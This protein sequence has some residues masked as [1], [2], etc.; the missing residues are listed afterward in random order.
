MKVLCLIDSLG[1]GGAQRQLCNLAVML[2]RRGFEVSVLTYHPFDFFLPILQNEGVPYRCLNTN[3]PS[4]HLASVRR[5]LREGDQ[6]VVLAFLSGPSLYAELAGL[7]NRRWG[8][9][10]SERLARPK[11]FRDGSRDWILRKFHLL[12]D[13]ITTN[14]HTNRLMIEQNSRRAG[15]RTVTI[16]NAIDLCQFEYCEPYSTTPRELRIAVASS[17]QEKKNPVRFIKAIALATRHLSD[18]RLVLD[19]YGG[20]NRKKTG[21]LDRR[22]FD[23]TIREIEKAGLKQVVRLHDATASIAEVY[24]NA[25][26]VALPSLFEG[27][28]N[29][30]C[31]GMA[32]GRP[33]LMSDV[34]DAGN[35]V[36]E[37]KNGFLFDPTSVED[38]ARAISRLAQLDSVQRISFG[39]TSRQMAESLFDSSL[40]VERYADALSA[41][42]NGTRPKFGHWP[43]EVP[44]SA[45]RSSSQRQ[46]GI[47]SSLISRVF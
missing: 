29:T 44:A 17:Y 30:I 6:D 1:S 3:I 22:V 2:K 26:V 33:I 19:W 35:L 31:E 32:T 43:P 40:V 46:D 18:V 11:T 14:S 10:V 41:A 45:Y 21:D 5:I 25:D 28:P 42:A 36:K 9:V 16:Y 7:P 27:L 4:K 38:M 12:A 8:L 20:F 39:K 15:S 23:A 47:V 24:R 13:V 37:G 34:C